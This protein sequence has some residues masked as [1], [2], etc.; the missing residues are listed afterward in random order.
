MVSILTGPSGPVLPI[1]ILSSPSSGQVS[2][3]TGPE[4]PVLL[5]GSVMVSVS[6]LVS[7]LTGPEGPVLRQRRQQQ[8]AATNVSILTGPEGPVLLSLMKMLPCAFRF[9]SSPAPKGRCY[10][11]PT[12]HSLLRRAGFN[13]HRPRRA[14]AT[15]DELCEHCPLQVSILTGPEGPVLPS[16]RRKPRST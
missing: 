15:T 13:P 8:T 4:G 14:G 9:Q 16:P 12:Q 5:A 3:L 11:E 10:Y 1:P 7:I 2:I 6:R